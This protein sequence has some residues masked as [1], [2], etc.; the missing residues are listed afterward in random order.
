MKKSLLILSLAAATLTP[1]A[2]SLA[3]TQSAVPPSAIDAPVPKPVSLQEEP[4]SPQP[5][6]KPAVRVA[7]AGYGEPGRACAASAGSAILQMVP[8]KALQR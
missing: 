2:L 6:C 8:G 7:Y 4:G 5:A 1:A 3:N